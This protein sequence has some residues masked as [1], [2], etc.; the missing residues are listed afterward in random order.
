MPGAVQKTEQALLLRIAKVHR[1]ERAGAIKTQAHIGQKYAR[2]GL[3]AGALFIVLDEPTGQC[4]GAR[5]GGN[6]RQAAAKLAGMA[7]AARGIQ[8]AGGSCI[9]HKESHT[10]HAA[11]VVQRCGLAFK[12]GP[13]FKRAARLPVGLPYKL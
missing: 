13:P 1:T 3:L 9:E 6:V 10:R 7:A 11:D 8:I 12:F 4:I 5:L 2:Y